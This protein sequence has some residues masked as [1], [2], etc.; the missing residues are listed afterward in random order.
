M[1]LARVS[2][3]IPYRGIFRTLLDVWQYSRDD[4]ISESCQVTKMER[5]VK[6]GY[7][8]QLLLIFTKL[9]ISDV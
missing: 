3:N 4:E 7:S 6:I 9:C 1:M 8:L 5:F 2:K